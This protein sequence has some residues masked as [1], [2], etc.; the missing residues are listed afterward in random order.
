MLTVD[1]MLSAKLIWLLFMASV[2]Q[3]LTHLHADPVGY[4]ALKGDCPGNNLTH[5]SGHDPSA[6]VPHCEASPGCAGFSHNKRAGCYLKNFTCDSPKPGEHWV[7]FG[8]KAGPV[9]P[10]PSPPSSP[11]PAPPT[12]CPPSCAWQSD[13]QCCGVWDDRSARCSCPSSILFS[14]GVHLSRTL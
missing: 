2:S 6:C 4:G 8:R 13:K 7:Y 14:A 9:P 12:T 1:I 3:C 10:S 5:F 11:P